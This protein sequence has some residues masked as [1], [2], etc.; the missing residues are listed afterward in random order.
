MNHGIDGSFDDSRPGQQQEFRKAQE[1]IEGKDV[2]EREVAAGCRCDDDGIGEEEAG[3]IARRVIE[4]IPDSE[5]R[6]IVL[7]SLQLGR[8]HQW[9]GLLPD[10]DSFNRYPERAQDKMISWND[11]QILDESKRNDRLTDAQ[12]KFKGRGQAMTFLLNAL[13]A[14]L[15]FAAFVITRDPASF[16]LLAVPGVTI[17]VNVFLKERDGKSNGDTEREES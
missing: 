12:I 3:E 1:G 6:E 7:G 5:L 10:P 13:F 14:V 9:V 4:D 17:A 2:E 11:A 16:T 8:V 15:S